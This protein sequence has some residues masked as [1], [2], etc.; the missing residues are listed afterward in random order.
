MVIDP[1]EIGPQE[2]YK[3][4]I[5]SVV[6]RPIALVSTVSEDGKFN[7]APFSFFNIAATT[8]PSVMFTPI[9]KAG[10]GE[11][12]DTLINIEQT[13]EFVVNIVPE[14]YIQPI[15]KTS[16]PY[17]SE[18]DEFQETGLTPIAS[19]L[20][21]APRCKESPIQFECKLTQV[22]HVGNN[23]PGSGDVVIGEIVRFHIEDELIENYRIDIEKL[24]PMAR[25]AG[26]SYMKVGD[27]FDIPRATLENK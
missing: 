18:V 21:K 27:I 9:R 24:K 8:P 10:T 7:I 16:T 12:K 23:T 19:D 14:G 22:V 15:H 3:L 17:P 26:N 25:L 1:N 20:V 6:P 2:R 13:K 11:K 5:G 4:L